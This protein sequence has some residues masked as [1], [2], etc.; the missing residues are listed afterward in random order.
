MD[1][2]VLLINCLHHIVT[3]YS[4]SLYL[5]SASFVISIIVINLSRKSGSYAVPK[6]LKENLLDGFIGKCLSASSNSNE[7]IKEAQIEKALDEIKMNDDHQVVQTPTTVP[8]VG[9]GSKPNQNEWIR[10][11]IIIDRVAFI[12]YVI[13]FI[14]MGFIHFI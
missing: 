3:F 2:C 5:L 10:L 13:I 11:A 1:M 14:L 7:S 6:S 4:H 12:I 8:N 9:G